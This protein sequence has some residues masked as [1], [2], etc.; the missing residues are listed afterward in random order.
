MTE[1]ALLKGLAADTSRSG[2]G[3]KV[4]GITSNVSR[5]APLESDPCCGG[6]R[7]RVPGARRNRGVVSHRLT[8]RPRVGRRQRGLGADVRRPL[9]VMEGSRVCWKG[10][11]AAAAGGGPRSLGRTQRLGFSCFGRGTWATEPSR[12]SP[13]ACG[14]HAPRS[15]TH[16]HLLGRKLDPSTDKRPRTSASMRGAAANHPSGAIDPPF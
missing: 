12:P 3:T 11:R 2:R 5:D 14:V 8:G 10:A 7:R 4:T 6:S 16:L 9:A 15:R 1:R 13:G